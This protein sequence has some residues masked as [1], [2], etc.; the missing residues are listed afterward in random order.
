MNSWLATQKN[1][2]LDRGFVTWMFT[3]LL[4]VAGLTPIRIVRTILEAIVSYKG[5]AT[6]DNHA[7]NHIRRLLNDVW[8]SI[9]F[10]YACILFFCFSGRLPEWWLVFRIY[11]IVTGQACVVFG[12]D[13]VVFGRK[14][15]LN[16][17][18][19]MLFGLLNYAEGVV[20]FAMYL[21]FNQANFKPGELGDDALSIPGNA[22]YF[23]LVTFTTVGFGDIVPKNEEGA[24]ILSCGIGTGVF[25]SLVVIGRFIGLIALPKNPE[26]ARAG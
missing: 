22:L 18:R 23:S 1:Q 26:N 6:N 24:R 14:F 12:T 4:F 5:R 17:E 19:T 3:W 25:L 15:Q 2:L 16:G 11:E 8:N 9:P 13:E 20:L 21:A 7:I 10:L